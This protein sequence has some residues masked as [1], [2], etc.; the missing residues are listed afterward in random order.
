MSLAGRNRDDFDPY[1]TDAVGPYATN[2][3]QQQSVVSIN[4]MVNPDILNERQRI[5]ERNSAIFGPE[6]I[7]GPVVDARTMIIREREPLFTEV[8]T[9]GRT[10]KPHALEVF[11]TFNGFTTEGVTDQ[12][13]FDKKYAFI[14]IGQS[15]F[16]ADGDPPS[17]T[18]IAAQV[19][20]SVTIVNNGLTDIYCGDVV[21]IRYPSINPSERK[22]QYSSLGSRKG[23]ESYKH[24]VVPTVERMDY[25]NEIG[26]L[27]NRI[28]RL[29]VENGPSIDIPEYKK[30]LRTGIRL[31]KTGDDVSAAV[32]KESI[33][34]IGLQT[35]AVLLEKGMVVPT[36]SPNADISDVIT[37]T[38]WKRQVLNPM[39]K[40]YTLIKKTRVLYNQGT[41][42]FD[43]VPL[44]N[45]ADQATRL[46]NHQ[47][48][49]EVFAQMLGLIFDGD[50]LGF[51]KEDVELTSR[52]LKRAFFGS[53]AGREGDQGLSDLIEETRKYV[54]HDIDS[55]SDHVDIFGAPIS[56]KQTA[57]HQLR[58][59]MGEG[60]SSLT[61]TFG[62]MYHGAFRNAF[63][64][65][66]S[67]I[68]IPNGPLVIT[69]S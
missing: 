31:L 48:T 39:D 68:S 43:V 9:Q 32:H 50:K 46:V 52:L 13:D 42:S 49:L 61:T 5:L 47:K 69:L 38:T 24:R 41:G 55:S 6:T 60:L 33:C 20:G 45:P 30:K 12:A 51:V 67:P 18:G 57:A 11:A 64:T 59:S 16:Y 21:K 53:L 66:I 23:A 27:A 7:I 56:S 19:H 22:H 1:G 26:L 29:T 40:D 44:T 65:C 58:I 36:F 8:A 4:T 35:V 10:A 17:N 54:Y 63:A 62:K 37:F 28:A 2:P 14:G 25:Q 34:K 15:G 3:T